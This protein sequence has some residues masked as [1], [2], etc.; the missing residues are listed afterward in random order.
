MKEHS[1][2]A[3]TVGLRLIDGAN[4]RGP[5]EYITYYFSALRYWKIPLLEGKR[6]LLH[7][8]CKSNPVTDVQFAMLYNPRA[9]NDTNGN[10][11]GVLPPS[12]QVIDKN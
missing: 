6:S 4:R 5:R 9:M 8:I 2:H 1:V 10:G 12:D 11:F 3:T 7:Y